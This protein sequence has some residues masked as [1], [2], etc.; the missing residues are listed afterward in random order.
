L[1]AAETPDGPAQSWW[2]P[3]LCSS[4]RPCWCHTHSAIANQTACNTSRRNTGPATEQRPIGRGPGAMRFERAR[5]PSAVARLAGCRDDWPAVRGATRFNPARGQIARPILAASGREMRVWIEDGLDSCPVRIF[6][7][8]NVN[9][10]GRR[11]RSQRQRLEWP[12]EPVGTPGGLGAVGARR[13]AGREGPASPGRPPT[14][15]GRL[16]E[17][18]CWSCSMSIVATSPL[19]T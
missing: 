8:I 2:P 11:H 3:A 15:I 13:T 1:Q 14:R 9:K 5:C 4:R 17:G 10:T 19:A 6:H 16:S 18:S 12:R 7:T